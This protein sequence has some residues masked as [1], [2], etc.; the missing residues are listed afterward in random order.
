MDDDDDDDEEMEPTELGKAFAKIKMGDYRTCLQYISEHPAVLAERETDG[1]LVMAFNSALQGKEDFARQ[2]VHQGLLLQYCR[3]LGK[4]G[5]GLFFK[6]ITT[7]GHQAQKM[8]LD[9]VNSTYDRIRTRTAEL[10][11]QKAEEPEGGV[12]QIQLH[13]VDP[14]TTI[15]IITPPPLDKCQSDDERASRSIFDTF[16]P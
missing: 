5:V 2:C 13:A 6:R 3:A 16:P 14:N 8:F 10:N 12:E 15:N 4:D 1:L 9:D 11:R 7:Q